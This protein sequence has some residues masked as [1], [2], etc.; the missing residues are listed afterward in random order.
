MSREEIENKLQEILMNILHGDGQNHTIRIVLSDNTVFNGF[1]IIENSQT[2]ILGLTEEQRINQIKG[3]SF[4][5]TT[6]IL[7]KKIRELDCPEL[8]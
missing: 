1:R 7:K 2:Y 8:W 5:L 3:E 4:F 6:V